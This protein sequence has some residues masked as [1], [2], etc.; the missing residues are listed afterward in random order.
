MTITNEKVVNGLMD[1]RQISSSNGV[2]VFVLYIV[3][4]IQ[5]ESSM[6]VRYHTFL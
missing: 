1:G 4:L 5:S 2:P 6:M 3:C